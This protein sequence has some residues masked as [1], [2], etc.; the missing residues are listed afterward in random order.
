MAEDKHFMADR[1]MAERIAEAARLSRGET[2]LEIGAGHGELTG[3]L[4]E[5]A[6]KV[7]AVEKDREL[8]RSLERRFSGNSR[9]A[10]VHGNAL[11]EARRLR[12]DR[13]VSN[14]PYSICEPLFRML[15]HLRFEEALLTVPKGFAYRLQGLPHSRLLGSET[16]FAVPKSA[17]SPRPRTASVLV[18]VRRT[19]RDALGEA[20]FQEGRRLKNAIMHAL[21]KSEG[22]TKK[23][24]REALNAIVPN[25]LL[26]RRVCSLTRGELETVERF[27]SQRK[28]VETFK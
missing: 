18:R 23:Q 28:K 12:F 14:L 5:R 10:L 11:L 13:I 2:V 16:I 7:I 24:S 21:Q 19:D 26:D 9:I 15:P 20:L 27:F 17:F 8:F 25:N 4:S 6:G 1:I 3:P 22:L